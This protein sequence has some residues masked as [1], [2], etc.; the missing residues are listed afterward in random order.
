MN[1][2]ATIARRVVGTIGV[3]ATLGTVGILVL[4]GWYIA[5]KQTIPDL[6]L[7]AIIAQASNSLG[8]LSS[9][10]NSTKPPAD[11]EHPQ[12]VEVVNNPADPVPVKD[13]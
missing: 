2:S 3:N 5:T 6:L 9:V 13:H 11:S 4:A 7:G 12:P 8:S 10:L 1:E